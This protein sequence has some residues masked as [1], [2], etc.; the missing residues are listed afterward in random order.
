M[1]DNRTY[2][3]PEGSGDIAAAVRSAQRLYLS[4]FAS[5]VVLTGV[6]LAAGVSFAFALPAA[7]GVAASI[8]P[9]VNSLLGR[10][11]VSGSPLGTPGAELRPETTDVVPAASPGQGLCSSCR[12]GGWMLVRIP[13]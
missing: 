10:Q 1:S 2:A 7:A 11:P 3:A 4:V 5:V 13:R 6:A 8:V 12:A 9:L